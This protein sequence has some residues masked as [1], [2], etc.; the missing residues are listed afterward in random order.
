MYRRCIQLVIKLLVFSHAFTLVENVGERREL[1]EHESGLVPALVA[2]DVRPEAGHGV[3]HPAVREHGAGDLARVEE[4]SRARQHPEG[5][6]VGGLDQLLPRRRLDVLLVG[7][8][9]GQKRSEVLSEDPGL[10][11]RLKQ[12]DSNIWLTD[13]SHD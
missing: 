10:V 6:L 4:V 1:G 7:G 9:G 3:R 13:H 2:D 8:C 12:K 5:G 11:Q